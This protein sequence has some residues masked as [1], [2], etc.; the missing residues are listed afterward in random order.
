ML[1]CVQV[2]HLTW[3]EG[4]EGRPLWTERSN[5]GHIQRMIQGQGAW[6]DV[7]LQRELGRGSREGLSV[8]CG[9]GGTWSHSRSHS[10]GHVGP[11]KGGFQPNKICFRKLTPIGVY[12]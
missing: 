2:W 5:V 8:H 3:K 7:W 4:R 12:P 11:L 1:L 6:W 10:V 9:G